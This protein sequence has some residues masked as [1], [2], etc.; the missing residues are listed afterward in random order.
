MKAF[1]AL[2][3]SSASSILFAGIRIYRWEKE[4]FPFSFRLVFI[5]FC[6]EIAKGSAPNAYRCVCV[7]VF[8]GLKE[9]VSES[10]DDLRSDGSFSRTKFV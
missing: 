8:S 5:D 7:V 1:F 3:I 9:P 4:F 2:Q 10:F 6:I